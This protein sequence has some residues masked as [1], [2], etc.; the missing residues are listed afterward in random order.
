M[1][2]LEINQLLNTTV[3]VV[4]TH[5]EH[6]VCR[7]IGNLRYDSDGLRVESL[8]IVDKEIRTNFVWFIAEK[9]KIE[10]RAGIPLI[11]YYI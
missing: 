3:E 6:I 9:S 2:Q 8:T 1:L 11:C 5:G 4:V 10:S 7:V